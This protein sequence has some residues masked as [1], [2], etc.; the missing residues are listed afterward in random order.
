[1]PLK[2]QHICGNTWCLRTPLALLPFYE[3]NDREVVLMDSGDEKNSAVA[4]FFVEREQTVTAVLLSHIHQDHTGGLK[5]LRR[6]FGSKIYA[7]ARE[8]ESIPSLKHPKGRAFQGRVFPGGCK[9]EEKEDCAANFRIPPECRYVNIKGAEFDAIFCPGHSD[10]H[11]AFVTPDNVCFLGDLVSSPNYLSAVRMLYIKNHALD[12]ESKEKLRQENFAYCVAAHKKVFSGRELSSVIDENL[13]CIEKMKEQVR[14]C[15]DGL[16]ETDGDVCAQIMRALDR[17]GRSP[18]EGSK[19]AYIM[20]CS[21]EGF[22]ED[23]R[24]TY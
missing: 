7:P 2:V 23:I 21:I 4:D 8:K 1:M 15:L 20:R 14:K 19:E 22:L 12:R 17:E 3:I 10:G 5:E 24:R 11:T 9:A 16:P 6:R 13:S 18:K